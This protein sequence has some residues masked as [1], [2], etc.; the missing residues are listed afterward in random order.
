MSTGIGNIKILPNQ[1]EAVSVKG[2]GP[3]PDCGGLRVTEDGKWR[4]HVQ[5]TPSENSAQQ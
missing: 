3:K 1:I 4:E 2:W 5:T